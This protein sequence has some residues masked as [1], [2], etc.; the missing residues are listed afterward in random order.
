SAS[1]PAST[2]TGWSGR[3][4]GWGSSSARRCRGWSRARGTTLCAMTK[5]ATA[6]RVAVVQQPPVTLHRDKT[7][8]R[9]V[10]LMEQAAAKGASLI[11]FPET[12]IPGYPEWLWR[13]RP[14]DDRDLTARTHRR[15]IENSVDLKAGDLKPLQAA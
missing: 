8:E 10:E 5:R 7:L 13:L 11:S 15:L 4:N 12:W 6:N 9:G 14:G 3:R 1:R 2:S